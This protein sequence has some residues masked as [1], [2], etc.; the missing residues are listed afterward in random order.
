MEPACGQMARRKSWLVGWLGQEFFAEP[1]HEILY[2]IIEK[3]VSAA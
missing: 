1:W 3:P 2:I